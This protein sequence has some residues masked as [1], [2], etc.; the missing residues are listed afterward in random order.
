M[1]H[2]PIAEYRWYL[3]IYAV[4]TVLFGLLFAAISISLPAQ[5]PDVCGV[6]NTY[7]LG[8]QDG[9]SGFNYAALYLGPSGKLYTKTYKGEVAIHGN[10]YTIQVEKLSGSAGAGGSF[11]E[12]SREEAWFFDSRSIHILRNDTLYRSIL[13]PQ[14]SFIYGV[15]DSTLVYMF[16]E[17]GWVRPWY[18]TGGELKRAPVTENI[19]FGRVNGFYALN[20]KNRYYFTQANEKEICIYEIDPS[21]FTLRRVK[22]YQLPHAYPIGF[23]DE[24]NFL[25]IIQIKSWKNPRYVQVQQG[26]LSPLSL[27]DEAT[28][29]LSL[30]QANTY[31]YG[32]IRKK[33]G[34]YGML[35]IEQKEMLPDIAT[36]D[37]INLSF[38]DRFRET[39]YA[40]T[41]NK[42]IRISRNI[43]KYPYLFNNGHSNNIFSLRQDNEGT[44]WAGS[45]QG[46]ISL[47]KGSKKIQVG[48]PALRITNGGSW[49]NGNMYL[50]AEDGLN[51]ILRVGKKG[52]VTRLVQGA[53]G[54]YSYL[55]RNRR[56]LYYGTGN[57][58]G[59]WRF[60]TEGLNLPSPP[61]EKID[62][63]RGIKLFNILTIAED[64]LGRIWCGHPKRGLAL[65]EPATGKATTW[66]MEKNETVFGAYSSLTD[67]RGVVWIGA[68]QRGLW[69]YDDYRKPAVPASFRRVSH[70]LLNS[71]KEITALT[72]YKEWLV[73]SA[74]DKILLLNLDSFYLA[75]KVILRYLNPQETGFTSIT[76]QNTLL[77]SV[78][79]STVWFSTSDMLYQW[80]IARWLTLPAPRVQATVFI[81]SGNHK[82]ILHSGRSAN[83]PPGFGSFDIQL[84]YISADN[85]PR[86]TSAILLKDGDTLHLPEPSL[87]STYPVRNIGSG[88]YTYFVDIY[89]MDGT[90][91]HY[92]YRFVIRKFIWQHWWFWAMLSAVVILLAAWLI[93]LRRKK[94]LAEEK[95]RTREAELLTLQAEQEKKLSDLRLLSLSSQFRPHFILNA[96]NTIGAKMDENPDMESVL[97]RL[98]ESA[99][100]IFNH[101]RQQQ[102]LHPFENEWKL[103]AN[104]IHIHRLMYLKE[105]QTELPDE[106]LLH[107]LARIPVPM[108]LLQ[109]PVENALLHGLSN[110]E[111]GPWLLAI[112]I[113]PETDRL[114]ITITDNGVGRKK[115]ALLSNYT[116]H[117]TGVRNLN[118]IISIINQDNK[119]TIRLQYTD[120]VFSESGKC[121]GTTVTIILPLNLHD[122]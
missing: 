120:D 27:L 101:S 46:G 83:F 51:G 110:R 39:F 17:N 122:E 9:F 92:I 54:F 111:C 73:I 116:R 47:I 71:G 35:N 42:P 88:R 94:Q 76:E 41:G 64:S 107:L 108:G 3:Y 44:I 87:Q 80:D 29:G 68:G 43:R 97:S 36:N 5:P 114:K 12:R 109:I 30:M 28:R 6:A 10:N 65:Y 7:T 49:Y 50:M 96:L 69:C 121:F 4:K 59:L 52:R 95:G 117:G 18:F 38:Q 61:V 60:P 14:E 16:N 72:E 15:L 13:L 22:C 74:Y 99:N 85:M 70:P 21:L 105:L 112:N 31:P 82:T 19:P 78:K 45:Y 118:E 77:T 115:S 1:P 34:L 119:E 32:L 102:I 53:V 91:S 57:Y 75:N 106:L 62:S 113:N 100:L 86:Y 20:R 58:E 79:D 8:D 89:E 67:H 37:N 90:T 23:T 63:S 2:E 93:N 48:G 11:L 55:S 84:R 25:A 104:I 40:A 24:N 81:T 98:G 103:V 26:R 33:E 56:H 66:L